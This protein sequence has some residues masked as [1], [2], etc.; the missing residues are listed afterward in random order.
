[1]S[2]NP[3]ADLAILLGDVYGD[4]TFTNFNMYKEDGFQ[5]GQGVF[6]L[7][8]N[9]S[10]FWPMSNA[11]LSQFDGTGTT[12]CAGAWDSGSRHMTRWECAIPWTSLDASNGVDSITNCSLAG[13]IV[14]SSVNTNNVDRYI[15][16]KYVGLPTTSGAKDE[17]GS[18]GYNFVNLNGLP[19]ERPETYVHDVPVSWIRGMFGDAYGMTM[20]SD[21]DD[22]GSLDREG[23]AGTDPRTV[24]CLEMYGGADRPGRI[25]AALEQRAGST[26]TLFRKQSPVGGFSEMYEHLGAGKRLRQ[27][28]NVEMRFA[29]GP[30]LAVLDRPACFG[31]VVSVIERRPRCRTM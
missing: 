9:G 12:A 15:S 21:F 4:G 6:Y 10:N 8:S 22:D 31:I 1:M 20:T 3:P 18:F 26:Y 29:C 7:N 14:S 17:Y 30:R 11:R 25:P 5:F 2:F 27:P 24:S 23:T 28:G 19:V 16:G 13:L